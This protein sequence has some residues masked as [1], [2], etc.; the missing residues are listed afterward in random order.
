LRIALIPLSAALLLGLVLPAGALAT[1]GLTTGFESDSYLSPDPAVR[2]LWLGKTV[3]AGAGIIRLGVPWSIY[4]PTRP[5]NPRDPN[6]YD[7]SGID[8]AVRDANA[9]GLKVMLITGGAPSWAE[10]AGRPADV[11]PG[12]WRPNPSDFAD[13]VNALAARYNGSFDPD[14][15]G[16]Q[17]TVPSAQALEVWNEE[18][19]S[20]GISPAFSGK[21]ILSPAIY[22]E[23]LNAAYDAVKSANPKMLVVTGGTAPYGDP[24]G[25]PYP[26]N[27]Q[28][29]QPVTFWQDVLCVRPVKGKKKGKKK[30][31][32]RYVRTSGCQGPVKFDVLAHHPIDN[33]GTGPLT[34]GPLPGDVSTPDLGRL[35]RVLRGAE[36]AGT[37]LAGKH[38]VWVTEFWWDSKPPNPSGAKLATQARWIEQSLYLFWKGG[39]STAFAFVVGDVELRPGVR[40][41]FQSGVYF[42]DGRP[43]PSLIAFRFPFVTER[44][45]KRH[46]TA[47][48]KSPTAGKLKIQ[49]RQGGRWVTLRKLRVGEGSVFLAK[50]RVT[51][52]KQQLRA[53]IGPHQSLVWKQAAFATK[54]SDD[55]LSGWK[56]VLI[57]VAGLMLLLVAA[58]VIRRRQ[59]VRRRRIRRSR[60]PHSDRLSSSTAT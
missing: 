40:A 20:P 57:G 36:K 2:D 8:S 60:R 54:S 46:L 15:A 33:T 49:R 7:L 42:A 29:V 27:F 19:T 23:L 32:P 45:D 37:T 51:G 55:G 41:G 48:G 58:G 38:Q 14:G 9:H 24:P 31:A 52:G 13:F 10:G 5:A 18:N 12:S 22:R 30:R 25:G 4:A 3:N 17:P 47:W 43:K 21:T 34:H 35:T 28:R 16:P 11:E 56:F 26:P 39:A 50:L 1:R 59:V 53:V 6:S 44:L